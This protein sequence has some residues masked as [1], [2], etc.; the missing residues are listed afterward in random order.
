M[1]KLLQ[2]FG[3]RKGR[4]LKPHLQTLCDETLPP[5][6]VPKSPP[7]QDLTTLFSAPVKAAWLE[8]GFGGGEHL[9]AQL[10]ANP[11]VGIIGCEPFLNGVANLLKQCQKQD[12]GRLRVHDDDVRLLFDLFPKGQLER[13]YILFPDPWPKARHHKRRLIQIELIETL[14]TLLIPGGEIRIGTDDH[15]YVEHIIEV[16]QALPQFNQLDGPKD[17]NPETWPPRPEGWPVTRYER[18][19]VTKPGFF[20]F[21]YQPN[22]G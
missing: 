7:I 6:R 4:K 3:R 22:E 5:L 2:T 10:D 21:S 19:A 9:K 17:P 13:I 1:Y 20:V 14:S 15:P 16:F 12:L 18:K 11:D 8:I